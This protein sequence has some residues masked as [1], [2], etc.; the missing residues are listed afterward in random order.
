MLDAQ[1][2]RPVFFPHIPK[3]G[4]TSLRIALEASVQPHEILPD[5]YMMARFG[6]HYPDIALVME[7]VVRQRQ[8]V[9]I[10]RGHYH[11]SVRKLLPNP[12]TI[13]VLR[14]PVS[15]VISNL[16]HNIQH[17]GATPE[18]IL[19]DLRKGVTKGVPDNAMTRYLGGDVGLMHPS[20]IVQVQNHLL[21]GPI[22]NER[23]RLKSAIEA[24]DTIDVLGFAE[25]LNGISAAL[26][27]L[28]I[29]MPRERANASKTGLLEIDAEGQDRIREMNSL[30][31]ELYETARLHLAAKSSLR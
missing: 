16:K 18:T 31:V 30:D 1:K 9:R 11:L 28:G 25:N 12:I 26:A 14:D 20:N 7:N 27:D 24:L 17:N 6:G 4:G 23:D 2:V 15:R 29:E 13:T 21:Y 5:I 22:D 3:T 8:A 10:L 19:E